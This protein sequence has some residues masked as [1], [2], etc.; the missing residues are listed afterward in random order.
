MNFFK[1]IFGSKSENLKDENPEFLKGDI[2]PMDEAN[3]QGKTEGVAAIG[4]MLAEND[5]IGFDNV[6]VQLNQG[7][8]S[9][10]IK[11]ALFGVAVGDAL[12]V[13]VEFNSREA[14]SKNPV[15]DM[16]G[17]GTYHLP[18]GTWSD[19]SSLAFCLA[20]ALTQD[21][22]LHT[23]GQNFV[24]WYKVNFWTPRGE[25]F[26]IGIGTKEAILRLDRG[27]EA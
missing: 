3:P 22:D 21:F 26:D 16:I 9:K 17:Y 5:A 15:T 4:A 20:E 1:K 7:V 8:E 23:I 14:I 27:G 19:D 11:S 12:G 18:A 13:P 10:G 6:E 2:Y 25:V 24:K